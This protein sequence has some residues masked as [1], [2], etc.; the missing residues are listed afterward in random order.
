ME[1]KGVSAVYCLALHVDAWIHTVVTCLKE[2]EA[3]GKHRQNHCTDAFVGMPHLAIKGAWRSCPGHADSLSSRK[4]FSF[5]QQMVWYWCHEGSMST[6][7]L[8]IR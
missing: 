1:K 6:L 8:L 3:R 7:W 4:V 5:E 2:K